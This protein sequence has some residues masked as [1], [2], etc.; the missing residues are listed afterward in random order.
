MSPA[1]NGRVMAETFLQR[2]ASETL[3]G[4]SCERMSPA[5]ARALQGSCRS[6]AEMT[7]EGRQAGWAG[8]LQGSR[9]VAED[10]IRSGWAL[11]TPSSQPGPGKV[12]IHHEQHSSIHHTL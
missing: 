2:K 12:E 10:D 8:L 5:L 1:E 7:A 3:F 9:A 6:A 11:S 4:S